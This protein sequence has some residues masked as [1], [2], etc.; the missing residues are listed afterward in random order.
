MTI[1]NNR[2]LNSRTNHSSHSRI[3]TTSNNLVQNS[4]LN[5]SEN[6]N[7]ETNI[8]IIE[9]DNDEI[10]TNNRQHSGQL[11]PIAESPRSLLPDKNKGMFLSKS[12]DNLN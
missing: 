4:R 8:L 2:G 9:D 12:L 7:K 10:V 1:E 11:E 3:N 6:N 5:S